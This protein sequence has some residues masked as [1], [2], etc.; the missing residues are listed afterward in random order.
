[1]AW[2]LQHTERSRSHIKNF[3]GTDMAQTRTATEKP[4]GNPTTDRIAAMAHDTVDRVAESAN[5]A[6]QEVRGA[7]NRAA[8]HAREMQEQ[9]V[10]AAEENVKKARSYIEENPLMSAGIAFAAGVVLSA[11]IRR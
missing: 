9:A 3:G 11:L 7:A 5:Y 2:F 1:V 8:E 10:A 4:N 6:E